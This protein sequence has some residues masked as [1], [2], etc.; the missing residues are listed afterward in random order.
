[1]IN[2]LLSKLYCRGEL[3]RRCIL[4]AFL[5]LSFYYLL[6]MQVSAIWP[7]TIDDMYIPLR[8]AKHWAEGHGLLWNISED[9]V[10]GYSNFSF[11]VLAALAIQFNLD[12]V[13]TLKSFGVLGLL[14]STISL[15]G[16]SRLWFSS[17]VAVI[18]CFWLLLYNGE[19]LWSVSGLE[20]TV[21]QGLICASLFFLLRAMGYRSFPGSREEG[22][23]VFWVVTG[24]L[25]A[26]ASMT[27]PEAPALIVVFYSWALFDSPKHMKRN[28]LQNWLLSCLIFFILFMPYFFWRWHYY[29]RLF[30]N[31]IYCKG[32]VDFSLQLDLVYL[33]LAWPF[34]LLALPAII[35]R[36]HDKRNYFLW[37]PSL[38]YLLLLIGAD[39]VAAFANRLFLPAFILLLPLTLQGINIA[40]KYVFPQEDVFYFAALLVTVVVIALLFIPKMTLANYRYFTIN[41]KLGLRLRQNVV[42]WLNQHMKPGSY[43]VL[44]DSGM[45][46]YMSSLNFIDS[47]CLNNKQMVNA[48]AQDMYFF[49]CN[50]VFISHPDAII[51]T[52]LV[53]KGEIRYTPA[54]FCLQ[55]RLKNTNLYK[56]RAILTTGN[57]KSLYRYEIYTLSK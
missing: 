53:E 28:Y 22:K 13:I 23:N 12:P 55:Q 2:R 30:P 3:L 18:P 24:A 45:I 9:P 42:N 56:F 8:Y 50:Q 48:S 5:L 17:W 51:L 25:F 43:V 10:E 26:L 52:S 44:A 37:L 16:L 34:I 6:V 19:I 33:R 20:T 31:A 40:I 7:F 36:A 21:Y 49:L 35:R 39:P 29:G 47:Y 14:V 54:D 32:L 15:Y 41:P 1:M 4:V 11:V 38:I 57:Q 27:R 46:P